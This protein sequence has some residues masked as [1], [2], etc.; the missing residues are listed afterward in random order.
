MLHGGRLRPSHGVAERTAA[1]PPQNAKGGAT[2]FE[3]KCPAMNRGLPT[4]SG[5]G[6]FVRV[7]GP[8]TIEYTFRVI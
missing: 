1:L 4:E 2:L 6:R 8:V 7:A 3:R 5:Q